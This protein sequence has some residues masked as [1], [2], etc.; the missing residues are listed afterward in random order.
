VTRRTALLMLPVVAAAG[1]AVAVARR[2]PEWG[3]ADSPGALALEMFAGIALAFAALTIRTHDPDPRSGILLYLTAIAW[4]VAE[5]NNPG[6]LGPLVFTLG[7]V[8]AYTA[9][10]LAAHAILVHGTGRLGSLA[11]RA[12]VAA[13]YLGLIG[14]AGVAATA[15]RDPSE[16]GCSTC[17]ANLVALTNAPD[18]AAWLERWGFRIGIAAL[19]VV[20]V[21]AARRA[22]RASPAARAAVVPVLVPGIAFLGIV[23]AQLVHD[24]GAVGRAWTESTRPC[25]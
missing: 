17:P 21:L 7:M 18:S 19:A 14:M 12:A 24:L 2:E 22:W 13:G 9:P 5:W 20:A 10:A 25:D 6:S 15:A 23:V 8:F 16:A 1:V 4:P 11:G 3:L